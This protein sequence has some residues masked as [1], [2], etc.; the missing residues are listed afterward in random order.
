MFA[1]CYVTRINAKITFKTG[2]PSP[3]N[4]IWGSAPPALND[5]SRLL[6]CTVVMFG[7]RTSIGL[8]FYLQL[9]RER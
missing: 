8:H 9:N 1:N 2:K 3:K 5:G 7:T 4:N 6:S